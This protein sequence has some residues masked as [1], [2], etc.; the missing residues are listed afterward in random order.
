[1]RARTLL[2]AFA[3]ATAL[4]G[5]APGTP[6]VLRAED[7][8]RPPPA[9][10]RPAPHLP[11][12]PRVVI[13]P[14]TDARGGSAA[15]RLGGRTVDMTGLE[16]YL[17]AALAAP[18][19]GFDVSRADDAA[20]PSGVPALRLRARI[21]KAYIHSL[22]TSKSA[23]V[24]IEATFLAPDGSATVSLFRAQDVGVNWASGTGEVISAFRTAA[25][26]CADQTR[27]AISSRLPA[28]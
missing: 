25:E 7:L 2:A 17:E 9:A 10:P 12:R 18:A 26:S 22:S 11:S 8:G 15:G 20:A 4:G 21:L 16:S 1:M 19:D 28:R 13:E 14:V 24:V 3:A 27:M 6:I 23:V 5:C